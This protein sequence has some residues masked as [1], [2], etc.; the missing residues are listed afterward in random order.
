M[1]EALRDADR[2]AGRLP[3][4]GDFVIRC[5]HVVTMD[6]TLGDMPGVDVL[7]CDG[8]IAAIGKDV[9]A[10]NAEVISGKGMM[11]LPGFI[12]THFHS[13]ISNC[14]RRLTFSFSRLTWWSG[15]PINSSWP[16]TAG[17]AWRQTSWL[18]WRPGRPRVRRCHM[19]GY[20]V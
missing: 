6:P 10:G 2:S 8:E 15:W 4:R 1:V 16:R 9:P 5:A 11:L 20:F 17:R 3:V 7:V 14:W 13:G 12:D 18:L 19:C